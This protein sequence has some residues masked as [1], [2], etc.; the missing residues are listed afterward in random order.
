MNETKQLSSRSRPE[1]RA[2]GS[3]V[4]ALMVST[5][6]H[7]QQHLVRAKGPCRSSGTRHCFCPQLKSGSKEPQHDVNNNDSS[8]SFFLYSLVLTLPSCTTLPV[9]TPAHVQDS[10]SS[11]QSPNAMSPPVP[12][13]CVGRRKEVLSNHQMIQFYSSLLLASVP[14]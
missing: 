13:K 4:S 9:A 10:P 5:T 2:E 14:V 8:H 3:R 11:F 1:L 6:K 7:H 12:K